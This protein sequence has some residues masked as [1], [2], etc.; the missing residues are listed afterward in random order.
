MEKKG[1]RGQGGYKEW[2]RL[3]TLKLMRGGS[4]NYITAN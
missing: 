1:D 4:E 2:G 3:C